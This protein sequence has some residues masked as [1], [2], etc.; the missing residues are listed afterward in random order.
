LDI[1]NMVTDF[2]ST[3]RTA[4]DFILFGTGFL[5]FLLASAGVIVASP[6]AAVTGGLILLVAIASFQLRP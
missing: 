3:D 1:G 6:A 5:G 2:D 4:G